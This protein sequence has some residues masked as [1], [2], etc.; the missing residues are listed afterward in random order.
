MKRQ[1]KFTG[2]QQEQQH[3][4]QREQQTDAT[5]REFATAEEMLRY[6]AAQ[7]PVPPGIA[8]R[9]EKSVGTGP[10]RASVWW[11]RFFRKPN[12]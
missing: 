12:A 5:A 10:K 8:Q 2:P 9:L 1:M 3:G 4:E 7:T 6:D 11:R